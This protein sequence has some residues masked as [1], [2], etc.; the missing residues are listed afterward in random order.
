MVRHGLV[1]VGCL[2]TSKIELYFAQQRAEYELAK[3]ERDGSAPVGTNGKPR[4]FYIRSIRGGWGSSRISYGAYRAERRL[5]NGHLYGAFVPYSEQSS[6]A[7][8]MKF[9]TMRYGPNV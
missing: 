7:A 3:A 6:I 9:L 5:N 2:M 4:R 1:V 8:V